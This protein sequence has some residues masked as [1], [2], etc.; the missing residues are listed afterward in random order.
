MTIGEAIEAARAAGK[1]VGEPIGE[2]EGVVFKRSNGFS[3]PKAHNVTIQGKKYL[4]T[5]WGRS[6][7]VFKGR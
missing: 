3:A 4:V 1:E 2:I 7:K 6:I 5:F